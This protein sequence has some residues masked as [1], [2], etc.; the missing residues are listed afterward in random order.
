V[1]VVEGGGL[2]EGKGVEAEGS[3]EGG[4]E[5]EDLDPHHQEPELDE[6]ESDMSVIRPKCD[7][8][9][10]SVP[11]PQAPITARNARTHFRFLSLAFK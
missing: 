8:Y 2:E 4:F 11:Q 7:Y 3:S 1:G 6:E 9:Q 5:L 10:S